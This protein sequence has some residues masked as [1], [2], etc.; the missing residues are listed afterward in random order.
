MPRPKARSRRSSTPPPNRRRS[1]LSLGGMLSAA[2]RHAHEQANRRADRRGHKSVRAAIA[3][4]D[5]IEQEVTLGWSKRCMRWLLALMLLPACAV[6]TWTFFTRFFDATVQKGFW[7][8]PAF[9]YFATGCL[10]MVGWLWSGLLQK[11]FLYLYVL[12]HELTHVLFVLLFRGKVSGFHV[13]TSGGYITTNK[14]NLLIALSPYFV[15]FW[16]LVLGVVYAML[17]LCLEDLAEHWHLAFY[18]L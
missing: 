7:Q 3:A 11:F 1:R 13:S 14:T 16:S 12:G 5:P 18:A 15:P 2:N 6:S 8:T 17:R 4:T 9:W 10:I